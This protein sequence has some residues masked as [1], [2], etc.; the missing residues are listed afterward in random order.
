[1]SVMS[2]LMSI[3]SCPDSTTFRGTQDDEEKSQ[4]G[5]RSAGGGEVNSHFITFRASELN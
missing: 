4:F 2:E 5:A 3:S 1:M